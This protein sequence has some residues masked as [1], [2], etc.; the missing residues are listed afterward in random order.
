ML[1]A[2]IAVLSW[3]WKVS[4]WRLWDDFTQ[5][6]PSNHSWGA[7]G[8]AT[9]SCV[10]ICRWVDGCC[11]SAITATIAD[12]ARMN[13]L[14]PWSPQ[15]HVFITTGK[16]RA[17]VTNCR[18]QPWFKLSCYATKLFI[19]HYIIQAF[20]QLWNPQARIWVEGSSQPEKMGM[21]QV[22]LQRNYSQTERGTMKNRSFLRI[23]L[24]LSFS[25][26]L[27]AVLLES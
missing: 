25:I 18:D 5:E 19:S 26:G 2:L 22:R 13:S 17:W 1:I 21:Q 9:E 24:A 3:L 8:G 6:A 10:V 7:P 4:R 11:L 15:K 14:W 12:S 16:S 20:W 27:L 23:F